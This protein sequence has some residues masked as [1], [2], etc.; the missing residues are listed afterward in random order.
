MEL[1]GGIVSVGLIFIE[2]VMKNSIKFL[3]L[4]LGGSFIGCFGPM[5]PPSVSQSV[6]Q[7]PRDTYLATSSDSSHSTAKSS[8]ARARAD[9]HTPGAPSKGNIKMSDSYNVLTP[10]EASVLLHKGTER[11]WTG[12]YEFNTEKGTY[13]CRQCNAPLYKSDSKFASNCGWPSFDDEI[14]GAIE[15]HPDADGSRTEIVCTNCKGHLGHVFLG[16]ALTAKNTRHCVNSISM[17][18]IL[19][20]EKIPPTIKLVKEI[21]KGDKD[22]K[23]VSNGASDGK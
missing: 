11:A 17:K 14:K 16:E 23:A 19:E 6:A 13:L 7:E 1:S 5:S 12:E 8:A 3:L 20:G 4:V 9:K 21:D 15:R 2:D 22:G 18:F 10:N